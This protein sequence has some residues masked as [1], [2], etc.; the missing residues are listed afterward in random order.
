MGSSIDIMEDDSPEEVF[1]GCFVG[2]AGLQPIDT[3][4]IGFEHFHRLA[5]WRRGKSCRYV[6]TDGPITRSFRSR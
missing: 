4:D 6:R 1:W 2:L 5:P 3:A